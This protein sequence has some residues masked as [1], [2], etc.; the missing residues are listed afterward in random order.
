LRQGCPTE[1]FH[2]IAAFATDLNQFYETTGKKGKLL[3]HQINQ[4][5]FTH[6]QELHVKTVVFV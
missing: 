4:E 5:T 6:D 3:K 1:L 2:Q